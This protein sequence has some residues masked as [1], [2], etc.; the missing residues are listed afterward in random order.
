MIFLYNDFYLLTR[1][2]KIMMGTRKWRE[3]E[4]IILNKMS[5]IQK[6]KKS[7]KIPYAFLSYAVPQVCACVHVCV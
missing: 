1:K 5:Q 7:N 6:E 3:L 4:I 2:N